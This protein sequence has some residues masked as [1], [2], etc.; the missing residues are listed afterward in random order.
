MA[1]Q[2]YNISMT[3]DVGDKV[4]GKVAEAW[5]VGQRNGVDVS[6]TDKT[7]HNNAK[8]Y[9]E[10]TAADRASTEGASAAVAAGVAE[11]KQY[12]Q[13]AQGAVNDAESAAQAA[14]QSADEAASVIVAAQGP[15]IVYVDDD[16]EMY[17]LE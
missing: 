13:A 6:E 11:A 17:V 4:S 12:A 5:A 3:V 1:E 8:Y 10:L 16:G 14:Q 9:A 7:Y 2:G 15:G